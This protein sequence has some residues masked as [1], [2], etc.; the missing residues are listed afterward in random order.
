MQETEAARLHT[1][2]GKPSKATLVPKP[3]QRITK[4]TA[5]TRPHPGEG[6]EAAADSKRLIWRGIRKGM[7]RVCSSHTSHISPSP[8]IV[9]K[10]QWH[11]MPLFP[12]WLHPRRM[13]QEPNNCLPQFAGQMKTCAG[14]SKFLQPGA[15]R[16]FLRGGVPAA[17]AEHVFG[18]HPL[19]HPSVSFNSGKKN[20]VL[21]RGR[22]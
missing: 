12:S 6:Q 13:F 20:S 15:M 17:S 8:M 21:L 11:Q 4:A 2:T 16:D 18:Q 9:F 3:Y 10:D 7:A 22:A 19:N 5:V 14:Q 1:I